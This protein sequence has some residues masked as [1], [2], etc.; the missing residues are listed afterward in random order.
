MTNF[1]AVTATTKSF[2]VGVTMLIVTPFRAWHT[3]QGALD[4]LALLN[5]QL[6][7]AFAI[8]IG[9]RADMTFCNAHVCF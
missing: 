5:H 1:A 8:A 9:G 7:S 4:V 2:V 6:M 3:A